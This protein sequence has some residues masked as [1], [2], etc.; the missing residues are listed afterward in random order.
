[1]CVAP[2]GVARANQS[3]VNIAA[4]VRTKAELYFSSHNGMRLAIRDDGDAQT[5]V[6]IEPESNGA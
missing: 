3:E 5:S 4:N 6:N 1:M 2:N